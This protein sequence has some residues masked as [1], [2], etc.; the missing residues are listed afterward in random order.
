MQT[1]YRD[2]VPAGFGPLYIP[3]N[4]SSTCAG[5]SGQKTNMVSYLHR[6]FMNKSL[7][8]GATGI[9]VFSDKSFSEYRVVNAASHQFALVS[10]SNVDPA[11]N[12][13]NDNCAAFNSSSGPQKTPNFSLPPNKAFNKIH[14]GH[15]ISQ[16]QLG[17]YLHGLVHGTPKDGGPAVRYFS[18]SPKSIVGFGTGS[19]IKQD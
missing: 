3:S 15:S 14:I 4:V 17:W 12:P 7:P 13:L 10:G 1:F 5:T 19:H 8:N 6:H 9:A 16:P 11:G 18:A 2:V